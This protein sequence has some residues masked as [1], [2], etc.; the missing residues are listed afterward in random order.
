[1]VG[2]G[3]RDRGPVREPARDA[4]NAEYGTL[5]LRVQPGE[6][7]IQIDGERWDGPQGDERL[8]VQL[9]AGRHVIDVRKDGYREYTTEV[10]V[11]GGETA[12]LNVALTRQ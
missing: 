10:T 7:D 4:R 11:R 8:V 6:A 5:T 1:V 12:T 9:S 3:P 2:R